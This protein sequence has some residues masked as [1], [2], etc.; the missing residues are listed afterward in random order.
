MP[1]L[2]DSDWLIDHLDNVPEAVELLDRL[3]LEGIA[4]SVVTYMEVIQGRLR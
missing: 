2:I 3:A 1:Y 4:I